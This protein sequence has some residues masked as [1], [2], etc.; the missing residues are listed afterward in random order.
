MPQPG[1]AGRVIVDTDAV[2]GVLEP[3]FQARRGSAR[4]V[5]VL[6]RPSK[7]TTSCPLEEVD[8]ELED[9]SRVQLMYKDL[10]PNRLV[11]DARRAKPTFLC[12]PRRELDLYTGLLAEA[13]PGTAV[14]YGTLADDKTER[15]WLFL[16]RVA[17]VELYQVGEVRVWEAVARWLAR[18]HMRFVG[19]DTAPTK[20]TTRLVRCDESFYRRWPMR[21]LEHVESGRYPS[22][23]AEVTV[24]TRVIRG[25]D[26]VVEALLAC[27]RTVLHGECYASNVLVAAPD[28]PGRVCPVDWEMAALGPGLVDLAA[29]TSGRWAEQSRMA[30]VTAYHDALSAE[31]RWHSRVAFL[32]ALDFCRLHVAMQWLGW[33]KDW[34]PPGE[35]AQNWLGDSVRLAERLGF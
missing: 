9:G 8:L 28:R 4:I 12:D 31:H 23:A 7:Y 20:Y 19:E 26:R 5:N 1:D 14:C 11:G 21:A 34:S 15:Y 32:E 16:E 3:A 22:R 18:W 24:L 25:Y 33:A 29:L 27:D 35:H 10:S 2:R 6:R 17:G 13:R 30:I